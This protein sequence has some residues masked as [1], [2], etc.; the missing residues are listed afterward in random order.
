[1]RQV[2]TEEDRRSSCGTYSKMGKPRVCI[3]PPILNET[4]LKDPLDDN[5]SAPCPIGRQQYAPCP[6]DPIVY[7]L[8][9][10]RKPRHPPNHSRSQSQTHPRRPFA[11]PCRRPQTP[12]P[13][14]PIRHPPLLHLPLPPHAR[15]HRR[16]PLRPD[17]LL[18]IPLALS[19]PHHQ[20][21]RR[22]SAAGTRLRQLPAL[23]RGDESDVAGARRLRALLLPHPER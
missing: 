16:H 17:G 3:F 5:P 21:L 14:A 18:P 12:L 6:F 10:F 1:V 13:P 2:S 11:S 8:T 22:A 23:V 15:N 4:S 9:L 7:L 20:S 19:S